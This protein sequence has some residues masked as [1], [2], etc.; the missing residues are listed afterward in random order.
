[1]DFFRKYYNQ[2]QYLSFRELICALK[3][4]VWGHLG[5]GKLMETN[6]LEGDFIGYEMKLP[7]S[8]DKF[9]FIRY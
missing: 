8:S 4:C 7:L 6:T 1:M 2:Q 5:S 3:T 9:F